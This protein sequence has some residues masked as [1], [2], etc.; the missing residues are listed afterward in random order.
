M[1]FF[2]RADSKEFNFALASTSA[3]EGLLALRGGVENGFGSF[4]LI[5]ITFL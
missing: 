1:P 2:V 3:T 5:A 4:D